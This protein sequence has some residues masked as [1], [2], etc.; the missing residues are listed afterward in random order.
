MEKENVNERK[1]RISK[2]KKKINKEEKRKRKRGKGRGGK[3]KAWKLNAASCNNP[4]H[5]LHPLRFSVLADGFAYI[6]GYV[7]LIAGTESTNFWISTRAT[8]FR[9]RGHRARGS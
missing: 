7:S 9:L 3:K 1:H 2:K 5:R 8:D 6:R 4:F